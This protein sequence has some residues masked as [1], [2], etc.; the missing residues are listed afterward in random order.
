MADFLVTLADQKAVLF[1]LGFLPAFVDLSQRNL[2]DTAVVIAITVLAV[3]GVKLGYAALA[4]RAFI[5]PR[6][7]GTRPE[8]HGRIH[9]DRGGTYRDCIHLI[10]DHFRG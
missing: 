4:D 2:V 1:Y 6:R 8:Q 7:S 5:R 10:E 3:G 9:H